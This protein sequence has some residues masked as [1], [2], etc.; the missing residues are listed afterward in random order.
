VQQLGHKRIGA[1]NIKTLAYRSTLSLTVAAVLIGCGEGGQK[2]QEEIDRLVREKLDRENKPGVLTDAVLD[3]MRAMK[4]RFSITRDEYWTETGGVLAN[5]FI[6]LWYPPGPVSVTHGMFA[7]GQLV[8]AQGSFNRYFG[9]DPA[10]HLTVVCAETM[11]GFSDDTGLPWYVYAKVGRDEVVIQPIDVLYVRTLGEIAVQRTYYEWGINRLSAG[12]SPQWLKHGLSS[13]LAGEE[14]VLENQLGEF[15][16]SPAKMPL[17]KIETAL[18]KKKDRK[19]YRIAMYDAWRMARRLVAAHGEEKVAEVVL[20]LGREKKRDRAFETVFGQSYDEVAS[21][22]W[23]F[24][25]AQ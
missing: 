7:F 18:R 19:A 10:D 11:P 24:K 25:V 14:Q 13:L 9:R 12:R 16:D 6:E 2:S 22:A 17:D 23:D 1:R 8:A 3:T 21:Y 20:L 15:K 5:D 4:E